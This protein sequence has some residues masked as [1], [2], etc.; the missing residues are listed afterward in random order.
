MYNILITSVG[1]T[2]A[3]YLINKIKNGKFK[4]LK[5]T[6]ISKIFISVLHNKKNLQNYLNEMDKVFSLIS[7]IENGEKI[8]NYLKYPESFNPYI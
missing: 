6:G 1:G 2:L 3:P 8:E 5:I 4:D 7:R